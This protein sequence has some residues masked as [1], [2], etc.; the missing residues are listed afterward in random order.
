M[1]NI[2]HINSKLAISTVQSH[3]LGATSSKDS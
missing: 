1:T 2:T 3:E